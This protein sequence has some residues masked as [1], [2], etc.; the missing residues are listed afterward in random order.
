MGTLTTDLTATIAEMRRGRAEFKM[1]RTGIIH[2]PIGKLS[3]TTDMLYANT[4]AVAQAVFSAK[5]AVLRMPFAKFVSKV[6]LCSTMG[7]G[8]PVLPSSLVAA[9]EAAQAALGPQTAKT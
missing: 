3:S 2:V 5:P 4:G 8:V 9:M 6:H 7:A 1:D